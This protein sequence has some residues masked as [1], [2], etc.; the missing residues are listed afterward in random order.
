MPWKM[1]PGRADALPCWTGGPGSSWNPFVCYF[2]GHGL[3]S[4]SAYLLPRLSYC[5]QGTVGSPWAGALVVVR[6][7]EM[8][9][10]GGH[11]PMCRAPGPTPPLPRCKLLRPTSCPGL[12]APSPACG[13][14]HRAHG[15]WLRGA[16]GLERAWS[17][18]CFR[19][20]FINMVGSW[21]AVIWNVL[22][23]PFF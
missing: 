1:G 13:C 6:A 20:P 12:A 3:H 9:P 21:G 2:H 18:W 15:P 11:C 22:Y 5:A 14:H 19:C 17:C 8:L 16:H 4:R 23:Y 7:R 10:D